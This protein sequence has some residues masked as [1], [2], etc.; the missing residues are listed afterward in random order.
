MCDLQ[1]QV[2]C[3]SPELI[4]LVQGADF[5]AC[6]AFHDTVFGVAQRGAHD[7]STLARIDLCLSKLTHLD[8]DLYL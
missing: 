7:S 2:A 6:G 3:A 1:T 4:I 8:K 5:E